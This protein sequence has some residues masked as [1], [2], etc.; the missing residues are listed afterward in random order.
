[1]SP[2]KEADER[3]VWRLFRLLNHDSVYRYFRKSERPDFRNGSRGVELTKFIQDFY[4]DPNKGDHFWELL[5]QKFSRICNDC[6]KATYPGRPLPISVGYVPHDEIR[7]LK[8]REAF[9]VSTMHECAVEFVAFAA[10]ANQAKMLTDSQVAS[11]GKLLGRYFQLINVQP[12]KAK[13]GKSEKRHYQR[14][15]GWGYPQS[16]GGISVGSRIEE[17]VKQKALNVSK[18]PSP[19]TRLD[20]LLYADAQTL[21]SR[22]MPWAESELLS[23]PINHGPF[24]AIWLLDIPGRKLL[25]AVKL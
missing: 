24:N 13:L 3:A 20:L 7:R 19:P 1:M 10:S 25:R 6:W 22:L 12:F 14:R 15:P 11:A 8:G 9:K 21:A 16:G 23:Q 18:Y 17:L 2:K 4:G 5:Y